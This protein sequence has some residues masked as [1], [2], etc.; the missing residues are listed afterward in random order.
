[1]PVF[2]RRVLLFDILAI[3]VV[4]AIL[5]TFLP[6]KPFSQTAVAADTCTV[7]DDVRATTCRLADGVPVHGLLGETGSATYRLDAL[8]PDA[9]VT[10]TVR[11][12]GGSTTV[13]VLDWR[14]QIVASGLRADD[15]PDLR[16]QAT[17]LLPGTYA[18]RV[19]GDLPPESPDFE[20]SATFV[21]S[22]PV[23]QAVWPAALGTPHDALTGERQMVRTPRGGTP[24][25][26]LAIA[27][28]LGAPPEGVVGD[29]TLVTDV[30]FEEIV[31]S[32]AFT[33]R[34]RY[35]PEA[36]GGSGYVLSVDP[37]AG[38]ATL[39]SFDEGQRRPIASQVLLPLMP[40]AEG[41][42]RLV[43]QAVGPAISVTLD[44]LPVLDV[45]DERYPRGLI[46]VGVVTWSDPVAVLFDHI[47]V[48]T[49]SR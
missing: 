37:I 13:S 10:L 14:G 22:S 11:A 38:T 48:T 20:L 12:R 27:R 42:N 41:P 25:G 44:G 32:S 35:E 49:P 28:A 43:L 31:G 1:M 3:S 23:R 47:Q 40:T 5:L 18:V 26:G 6:T 36:G 19:S 4:T 9:T 29:F 45:T 46:A 16:I 33:V 7:T 2:L 21:Y 17:L 34:F 30:Q 15:A 39:D 8:G 24:S